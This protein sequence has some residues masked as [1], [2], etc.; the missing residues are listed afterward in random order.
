MTKKLNEA[1][2]MN[3]LRGQSAF[4]RS[5]DPPPSD[6]APVTDA[7][8]RSQP[9]QNE[10][11]SAP[12]AAP[13]QPEQHSPASAPSSL[14]QTPGQPPTH[15]VSEATMADDIPAS[16]SV[17]AS[18]Q[19][20]VLSRYHASIIDAIRKTVKSVGKEVAFVR[21]TPEEKNRLAD[22]AYTYRRQGVKTSENEISRIAI[23]F[24]LEDYKTNGEA[25]I[26]AKVLASLLA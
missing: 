22:I 25:S 4:F 9:V 15:A 3:E 8:F 5:S 20:S 17:L 1:A 6:T 26:L 2:I 24:L 18:N 7:V 13:E 21:L 23:N 11:I 19:A 10:A 16:A 12:V 14:A